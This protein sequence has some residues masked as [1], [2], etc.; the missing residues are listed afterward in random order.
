MA[1]QVLTTKTIANILMEE[2]QKNI[3]MELESPKKWVVKRLIT[4]RIIH[5]MQ[6]V[7]ISLTKK[8]LLS[9]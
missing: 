2:I 4:V 3:Q 1:K 8:E 6:V 9:H 7:Q 5:F